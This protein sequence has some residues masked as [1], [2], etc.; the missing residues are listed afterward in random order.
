MS[1]AGGEIL[2][3]RQKRKEKE[4]KK[5][6]RRGGAKKAQ[7][8]EFHRLAV[9]T[10][11]GRSVEGDAYNDGAV[12]AQSSA[13]STG[14]LTVGGEAASHQNKTEGLVASRTYSVRHVEALQRREMVWVR[15]RAM[16]GGASEKG[17]MHFPT[18][19]L[20]LVKS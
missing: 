18:L 6:R 15:N 8:C 19:T 13:S 11:Q 12:A 10:R 16:G 17:Q 1:N 20:N 4:Q 3:G 14:V 7:G 9:G 5:R 2:A